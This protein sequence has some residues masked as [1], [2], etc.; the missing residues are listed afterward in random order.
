MDF[1]RAPLPALLFLCGDLAG[2]TSNHALPLWCR[3]ACA[4]VGLTLFVVLSRAHF[5]DRAALCK[6]AILAESALR[7]WKELGPFT[8]DGG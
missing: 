7:G 5:K 4:L 2:Q 8:K 6:R 3:L 1:V